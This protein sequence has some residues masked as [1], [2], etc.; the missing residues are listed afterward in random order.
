[1][2][3]EEEVLKDFKKIKWTIYINEPKLI[4][5]AYFKKNDFFSS[6]EIRIYKSTKSYLASEL[7][8]Q[9]HK[10]LNELFQIWNWL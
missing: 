5:L 9:E 6:R 2:R 10:L 3:T 4:I 1:M 7:K 8:M